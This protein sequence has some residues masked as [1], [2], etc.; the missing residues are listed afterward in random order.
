MNDNLGYF[1]DE[2]NKDNCLSDMNDDGKKF[3]T[4]A[5]II[6]KNWENI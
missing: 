3:K 4:I 1:Y 5:N 6:E 2:K